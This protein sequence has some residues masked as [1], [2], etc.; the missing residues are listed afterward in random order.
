MGPRS[1]HG[2]LWASVYAGILRS[3][4]EDTDEDEG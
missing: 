1:E 3:S 4:E 2:R